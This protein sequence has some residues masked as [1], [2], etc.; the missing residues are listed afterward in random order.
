M[1]SWSGWGGLDYI[2]DDAEERKRKQEEE[3]K[4][5]KAEEA[6]RAYELARAQERASYQAQPVISTPLPGPEVGYTA[7]PVDT[8]VPGLSASSVYEP[9]IPAEE[10]PPPRVSTADVLREPVQQRQL[11]QNLWTP[12]DWNRPE[13]QVQLTPEQEQVRQDIYAQGQEQ[14]EWLKQGANWLGQQAQGAGEWINQNLGQ[15]AQWVGYNTLGNM[16][17]AGGQFEDWWQNTPG[18]LAA[19][20]HAEER[21]NFDTSQLPTPLEAYQRHVIAPGSALSTIPGAYAGSQLAGAVDFLGTALNENEW[22]R[23]ASI[24]AQNAIDYGSEFLIAPAQQAIPGLGVS[25]ID[26]GNAKLQEATQAIPN[27]TMNGEGL[28]SFTMGGYGGWNLDPTVW[29]T[30]AQTARR[31]IDESGEPA[32]QIAKRNLLTS[33]ESALQ[34]LDLVLNKDQRAARLEAEAIQIQAA[35]PDK[36]ARNLAEAQRLR[37]MTPADIVDEYASPLK[38]IF[39]GIMADPTT[40][41]DPFAWLGLTVEANKTRK[42]A[43]LFDVAAEDATRVLSGLPS[44]QQVQEGIALGPQQA[45]Q[46]WNTF[47]SPY[48]STAEQI[49][50][51]IPGIGRTRTSKAE[52]DANAAWQGVLRILSD[53]DDKGDAQRILSALTQAPQQLVDGLT[54]LTSNAARML[55]AEDGAVRWAPGVVS[56]QEFLRRYP[57]IQGSASGLPNMS[58]LQGTGKI[59]PLQFQSEL[60]ELFFDTSKRLNG[61]HQ[62]MLPFGA[63]DVRVVRNNEGFGVLEYLDKDGKVVRAT[64]ALPYAEA[65]AALRNVQAQFQQN[66]IVRAGRAIA[67]VPL[68][69]NDLQKA[70]LSDLWLGT[71]PANWIGNGLGAMT[72]LFANDSYTTLPMTNILDDLTRKLGGF[73]ANPRLFATET[74]RELTR[75]AKGAVGESTSG[76]IDML[77]SGVTRDQNNP[78]SKFMRTL[79]SIPYGSTEMQLGNGVAVPMGEQAFYAR[80]FYVPFNRVFTGELTNSANNQLLPMLQQAAGLSPEQ[81]RMVV[82]KVLSIGKGDGKLAIAQGIRNYVGKPQLT[83]TLQSMG[84]PPEL[85]S[86]KAIR[87]IENLLADALP[88]DA[89]EVMR[90][91]REVLDG[92][93]NPYG[94]L[95]N[96]AGKQPGIYN[97]SAVDLTQE[98][99]WMTTQLAEDARKAGID[100]TVATQQAEQLAR[101]YVNARSSSFDRVA[102]DIAQ[103]ENNSNLWSLVMDYWTEVLNTK[104][105]A[106]AQVDNLS[107]AAVNAGTPQAWEAKWTGTQKLYG[108]L[109][110]Q[111]GNISDNYRMLLADIQNGAEYTKRYDWWNTI[112]RYLQWDEMEFR[113]LRGTDLGS[114]GEDSGDLWQ[115]VITNNRQYVDNALFD[116]FG[117]FQQYPN[118]DNFDIVRSTMNN[119]EALGAQTAATLADARE[120]LANGQMSKVA[121]AK[122]RNKTWNNFFDAGAVY[123]DE[124]AHAIVYNGLAEQTQTGLRWFDPSG[125][126]YQ[127]AGLTEDGRYLARNMQSGATEPFHAATTMDE[128]NPFTVPLDVVNDYNRMAGNLTDDVDKVVADIAATRPQQIRPDVQAVPESVAPPA[129]QTVAPDIRSPREL[130]LEQA[131]GPQLVEGPPNRVQQLYDGSAKADP[132]LYRLLGVEEGTPLKGTLSEWVQRSRN[133][134]GSSQAQVGEMAQAQINDINTLERQLEAQLPSILQGS[135]NQMTGG[136]KLRVIDT[137]VDWLPEYDKAVNKGAYVGDQMSGWMMLNYNDKR[138]FDTALALAFPYSYFWSRMAPRVVMNGL[139]KPALVNAMYEINRGIDLEN[140]QSDVPARLEGTVPIPGTNARAGVTNIFRY[141]IPDYAAPSPFINP[142]DPG[143][144]ILRWTP[145]LGTLQQMAVDYFSNGQL[146]NNYTL[147]DLLP[148]PPQSIN[149]ARTGNMGQ[150]GNWFTSPNEWDPYRARRAVSYIAVEEG[151]NQADVA[152]AN[153]VIQNQYNGRPIDEGI[154][155]ERLDAAIALAQR[156]VKRGAEDRL[157]ARGTAWATGIPVYPYPQ[158]EQDM[159]ATQNAYYAAGYNP[160]TGLGSRELQRNFMEQ[161]PELQNW[162]MKGEDQPAARGTLNELYDQK[163]QLQ[164]DRDAAVEAAVAAAPI[165]TMSKGEIFDIREQAAAPYKEQIDAIN[166]QID[167]LNQVVDDGQ[168]GN[169]LYGMNPQE[170]SGAYATDVMWNARDLPGKP[171]Y[172]GDDATPE[173]WRAYNEANAAWKQQ[174]EE[175]VVQNIA[176]EY[177]S[178][179]DVLRERRGGVEYSENDARNLWWHFQNDQYSPEERA[180]FETLD[181]YGARRDSAAAQNRADA[182]ARVPAGE[183]YFQ[184]YLDADSATREEMRNKDW[185]YGAA[186]LAG[187]D[188]QVYDGLT[189]TLGKDAVQQYYQAKAEKPEYPAEPTDANLKT[190]YAA[191]DQWEDKYP[192][193]NEANLWLNGRNTWGSFDSSSAD[194]TYNQGADYAEAKRIFGDDI[195]DIQRESNAASLNGTY[196]QWRDNNPNDYAKLTG[197]YE[198]Q[199]ALRGEPTSAAQLPQAQWGINPAEQNAS[200]AP[201][202]PRQGL[203]QALP[204]GAQ[205]PQNGPQRSVSGWGGLNDILSGAMPATQGM[206]TPSQGAPQAGIM[207]PNDTARM[208]GITQPSGPQR[209]AS[210]WARQNEKFATYEQQSQQWAAR[211]AGVYN[212]FGQEVGGYYEQYL[213]LPKGEA[214]KRYKE[215]HPEL[216]AVSL[217]TWNPNEYQYL[218]DTYGQDA[219]MAWANTPAWADT[220]EAKARRSAY[221]DANPVAWEINAWL[222]GRPGGTDESDITDDE[223]FS[224]NFGADYST[225][226]EKFGADIWTVVGNYKRG[227]DKATKSAYYDQYPQLSEFF[228]WWYGNLPKSANAYNSYGYSGYGRSYGGYG[229]G[230]SGGWSYSSSNEDAEYNMDVRINPRYMDQGL[231]VEGRD[232]QQYRAPQYVGNWL[233]AGDRLRYTPARKWTPTRWG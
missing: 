76:F 57:I 122:L 92:E 43:Q 221:Y 133:A 23:Q 109:A 64:D 203:Q 108:E 225:A 137:I 51:F 170:V 201:G 226:K 48:K 91:I 90:L 62:N 143:A 110:Q 111:F 24:A 103:A 106:R 74:G 36:A 2:L 101:T 119:I 4:A 231:R 47:I 46:M 128:V 155:P 125:V 81:A 208:A 191:M 94:Q 42:A 84:I 112:E 166:A 99:G 118:A 30:Q 14:P 182:S 31:L 174:Q 186:L 63:V 121:Y 11:D 142:E 28:P 72:N 16:A 60:Y 206:Q 89:P 33:P 178:T 115:Q 196:V 58:S 77:A 194:F 22:G 175:Y 50:E 96:L 17:Q 147:N 172:P 32:A 82:D 9:T 222:Y 198:W 130:A 25:A 56:N 100:P 88:Q 113:R 41:V 211:K 102:S 104:N 29:M 219:I 67:G 35:D 162:W 87:N 124:M 181:R 184:R 66:P 200:F 75:G 145:G 159:R 79:Y 70:I 188:P 7:P 71:R 154:P 131:A 13:D 190:Y 126:E 59:D 161:N 138:G 19:Q 45:R 44:P 37:A 65:Q 185:R 160:D 150:Q 183:A 69:L 197:F 215:E 12:T 139:Q 8:G 163:Q 132:D 80:A 202:D 21:Q 205:T 114:V 173:Q 151:L 85:I 20:A 141:I 164:A 49:T 107:Q 34:T 127:L 152:Y 192:L 153:Q 204:Q 78:I 83:H 187:F 227:W 97:W 129:T 73:T 93:R 26:I 5:K 149:Q 18:Y 68:W 189:E 193:Y 213:S 214:R 168:P 148:I 230:W 53:I 135:P 55:M 216:R 228:D 39:W 117:A 179:S 116:V 223:T 209:T 167:E 134:K 52:L 15:G 180:R 158:S 1:A 171:T 169:P 61:V 27:L 120:A 210:Q 232:I 212:T 40:Y 38:E 136:Q 95:L 144:P 105:A 220:D 54:G 140:K 10:P 199:K 3:E 218:S 176:Q 207:A 217:Y 157:A 98:V 86:P 146:D 224:Y 195:F 6:R 233:N 229:G 123:A 177:T 156:G 165:N